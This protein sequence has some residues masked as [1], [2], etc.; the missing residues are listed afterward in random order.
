MNE[1]NIVKIKT[2]DR[3]CR[4]LIFKIDLDVNALLGLT[5]FIKLNSVKQ[6]PLLLSISKERLC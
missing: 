3:C 5:F 1:K 6:N 2:G 4:F